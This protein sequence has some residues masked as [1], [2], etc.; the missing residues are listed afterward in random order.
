M[1]ATINPRTV[2]GTPMK[3]AFVVLLL[4]AVPMVTA[5]L[6]V[7]ED[8]VQPTVEVEL[9]AVRAEASLDTPATYTVTVR[10]TSPGTDNE[11]APTNTITLTVEGTPSGWQSS[12]E[13][14]VFDLAPGQEAETTLTVGVSGS[15]TANRA[16]V[17]VEATISNGAPGPLEQTGMGSDSVTVQRNDSTT[18]EVA[19][20]VEDYI[21]IIVV[22]GIALYVLS[23]VLMVMLF[24]KR[25]RQH[26]EGN[27][28]KAQAP[29]KDA[30]KK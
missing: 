3:R 12:L 2:V 1:A 6:P 5:Q 22:G 24:R 23:T 21:W 18:R 9:E 28:K 30:G 19:E 8:Q 4:L 15:A 26:Q 25:D 17:T 7:G 11:D 27:V 14:T 29:K 16:Q 20:A 13:Q 10:N